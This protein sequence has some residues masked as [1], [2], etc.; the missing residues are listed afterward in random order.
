MNAKPILTTMLCAGLALSAHATTPPVWQDGA[1]LETPGLCPEHFLFDAP[2][3]AFPIDTRRPTRIGEVTFV[4]TE[5][6]PDGDSPREIVYTPDGTQAVII[7]AQTNTMT[8][9]NTTTGVITH[10]VDVGEYPVHVAVTPNGQ[11]ALATNVFSNTVSVVDIASHTQVAEIPITG[12]QP[13]RVA[14]TADG[15]KAIVGVIN[16]AVN[17]AFSVIDLATLTETAVIA[18]GSQ[19][20]I[21]GYATPEYGIFG[22]TFTQFSVSPDGEKIVLPDRGGDR[23]LIY[24]VSTGAELASLPT[25][26]QPG[27]VDIAPNGGFAVVSCEGSSQRLVVVDL[28]TNSISANFPTSANLTWQ[29]ARVTPDNTYAVVSQLNEVEFVN[30]TTGA[31]TRLSTGS[32]GDLEFSFDGQYLFVSNFSSRVISLATR[33]QVASITFAS[34]Y[35]AATSPTSLQA[36]ALNNRFGE[37][38]NIYSINGFSSSLQG[39]TLTGLPKEGDSTRSL[40]ITPDGRTLFVAHTTSSTAGFLDLSTKTMSEL[41]DTSFRTLDAAISPNGQYAV[42][43][44][45]DGQTV[46]IFDVP[47]Q[48]RVAQLS[49]VDRPSRVLI[50]PDSSTAYVLSIAG[51]DRV[52]KIALNGAASSVVGT[53]IAGQAGAI[54]IAFSEFSGI[55]LSPDGSLLAVARSFDDLVRLIDT[56]TLSVV[57]D[58]SVDQ[59]GSQDFPLRLTFN[60]TGDRL[61]A[62][63]IFGNAIRVIDVNGAASTAIAT[64]PVGTQPLTLNVDDAGDFLYVGHAGSSNG[65]LRV[66]DTA[67][68]T[69]VRTITLPGSATI[70]ESYLSPVDGQLYLAGQDN[71]GGK[72]WVFDAAGAATSFVDVFDLTSS[73]VDLA[74]SESLGQAIV[75]LPI[76]D[77]V[78]VVQIRALCTADI[79]GD[80]VVDILDLL[81]FLQSF[82]A[83]DGLPAPCDVGGVSA[84]INGDTVVD[85]LDLLDF[86]QAFDAQSTGPC[87]G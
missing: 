45:A 10:S 31:L 79:N 75:S 30:L 16:D 51:T 86:L 47:S 11:Y 78:D 48:A 29:K 62:A 73:P 46:S 63:N 57:A 1:P 80:T 7:H 50:S 24:S 56:Q 27:G 54:G 83:C 42:T 66:I 84:D 72:L 22:D 34:C 23:I 35:D 64:V 39:S 55:A 26:D 87:A 69:V 58:V 18:T 67:T 25:F 32:P 52:H 70:R 81:D 9:L 38:V 4:S 49:V 59:T 15:T 14:I 53:Q 82:D 2:V 76:P 60:P 37:N 21:G 41:K 77:G 17:S 20:V 68:N 40:D 61:Y 43:T 5:D 71:T 28:A 8:F 3:R 33:T 13:Y 12:D 19:G 6:A 85:V 74:F 36:V 44:N 65:G